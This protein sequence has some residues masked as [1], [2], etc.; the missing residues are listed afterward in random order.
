MQAGFYSEKYQTSN[1]IG[2]NFFL[3][4]LTGIVHSAGLKKLKILQL[5]IGCGSQVQTGTEKNGTKSACAGL[6][7]PIWPDSMHILLSGNQTL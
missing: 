1:L 5:L 7:C 4:C 3:S 6:I 2:L